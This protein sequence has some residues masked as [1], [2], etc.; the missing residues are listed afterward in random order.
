MKFDTLNVHIFYFQFYLNTPGG[1]AGGG[2][3]NYIAWEALLLEDI[4]GI[5]N[6]FDGTLGKSMAKISRVQGFFNF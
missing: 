2:G 3:R 4:K 5:V 6:G 1:G